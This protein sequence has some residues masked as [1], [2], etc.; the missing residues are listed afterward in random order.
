MR[1]HTRKLRT[2]GHRKEDNKSLVE[3]DKPIV[4]GDDAF[5]EWFGDIPKASVMLRGFRNRE[6]LTQNELGATLGI[7]QTNISQ[8]ERGV[9]SIGKQLAKRLAV[10]F[11]TDYRLFL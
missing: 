10:F 5:H 6:G 1:V 9:R 2:E 11:K 4:W 3:D 8:M 7:P